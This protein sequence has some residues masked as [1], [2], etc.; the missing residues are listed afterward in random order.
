MNLTFA[1]RFSHKFVTF[2]VY[3]LGIKAKMDYR[4]FKRQD[5]S[6]AGR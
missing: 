6:P 2:G 3:N 5:Q 4:P 1:T